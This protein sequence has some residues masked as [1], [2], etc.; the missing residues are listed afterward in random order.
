MNLVLDV[1]F[2]KKLEIG[3]ILYFDGKYWTN[4][5][6]KEYLALLTKDVENLKEKLLELDDLKK[7]VAE[8][9]GED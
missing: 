9:R 3:D 1:K 5:S 4:L 8:L 7:K 6:K 2:R